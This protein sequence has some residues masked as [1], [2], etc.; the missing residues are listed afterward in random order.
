MTRK[1]QWS[2]ITITALIAFGASLY[3]ATKGS[4]EQA[5]KEQADAKQL[6]DKKR[7]EERA[8]LKQE[9]G[10]ARAEAQQQAEKKRAEE[11]AEKKEWERTRLPASDISEIVKKDCQKLV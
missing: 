11:S 8:E 3:L 2:I 10:Q 6:A 7:A 9:A 5:E 4:L 1:W